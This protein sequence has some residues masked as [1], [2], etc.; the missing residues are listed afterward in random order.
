MTSSA[1]LCLITPTHLANSP[2]VLKE[3]ITLQEAGYRVQVVCGRNTRSLDK[4]DL[5]LISH[6]RLE[7]HRVDTFR[8]VRTL[9]DD[10]RFRM[11]RQRRRNR[12]T[13]SLAVCALAE[14]RSVGALLRTVRRLPA[15]DLYLGHAPSG[16]AAAGYA[17]TT[18]GARLGFDAEDFH[19]AETHDVV[20]DPAALHGLETI[21]RTY[22]PRCAHFTAA[23]P[24]IGDAYVETYQVSPPRTVLN[25][26]PKHEGPSFPSSPPAGARPRL[27]W[28]SQTIGPGRGLE[29]VILTLGKM[30][31]PCDLD[32]RGEAVPGFVEKLKT[33]SQQTGYRGV[34][35][36]LPRAA[37]E[38]LVTLT[39][40]YDLGLALEQTT[41]RNRDLCLT[42]KLF[43]YLLAGV[44]V[45][46]TPTQ[47]QRLFATTVGEAAIEL[48][49]H[50]PATAAH[51][52]DQYF[53]TPSAQTQAREQAWKVAQS[54]Y[55]WEFDAQEFLDS[56]QRALLDHRPS[57]PPS[58]RS[59]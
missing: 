1:H 5:E 33:L 59:V 37:P 10:L 16:L 2:R 56:L 32:L 38:N 22:L 41:P 11:A 51:R 35:Q 8:H 21:E 31:T 40:S 30:K 52:L 23:S 27:Y 55:H 24:L 4:D 39:T 12:R 34:L 13:S 3:A 43:T 14:N 46:Y 17:A 54:R 18:R 25:T 19:P 20:N 6:H 15:A 28:Y 53:A 44:P 26:F 48:P 36:I 7:V 42:N 58:R 9:F 29:A 49:L 50:E 45:A 57:R 47:A